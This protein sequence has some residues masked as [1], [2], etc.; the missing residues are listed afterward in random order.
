MD[1][2]RPGFFEHDA[3]KVWWHDFVEIVRNLLKDSRIDPKQILG[4]GTSAIG[5]CVLPIDE[6]GHALRPGILLELIRVPRVKSNISRKN[7][8]RVKSLL[9]VGP[10]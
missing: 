7:L 10:I 4:I 3:D 9:R 5:S 8:A 6:S 2:P 1:M